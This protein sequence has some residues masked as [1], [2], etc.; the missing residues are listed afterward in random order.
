MANNE[1]TVS[2]ND[3]L[4]GAQEVTALAANDRILAINTD[5]NPRKISRSN[6]D[7]DRFLRVEFP[8]SIKSGWIR[9]G[10]FDGQ[11][12][13]LLYCGT[14]WGGATPTTILLSAVAHINGGAVVNRVVNLLKSDVFTKARL[15]K[16]SNDR[17]YLDLYFSLR[18]SSLSINRI[19]GDFALAE[20]VFNPTIE[21]SDTVWESNFGGGGKSYLSTIC[22]KEGRRHERKGYG[23]EQRNPE[24]HTHG[25]FGRKTDKGELRRNDSIGRLFNRSGKRQVGLSSH[26]I[27]VRYPY[28]GS[29]RAIYGANI[30]T[31]QLDGRATFVSFQGGVQW[32]FQQMDCSAA[33]LCDNSV[34]RV[35]KEAAA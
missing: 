19:A 11:G 34:L 35:G 16:K 21:T 26:N 32:E 9:I 20:S 28:S 31:P 6:L 23:A 2:L 24:I 7:S 13:T 33:I 3:V 25:R 12:D 10:R 14:I 30:Y 17:I 29:G 5:G 22:K 18:P 27:R 1:K 15:V 4:K 8:I